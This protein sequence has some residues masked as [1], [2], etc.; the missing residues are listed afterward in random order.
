MFEIE[1]AGCTP[2][3]LMNY[4][5]ALG[6]FRLVAEQ[7][8]PTAQ[9]SLVWRSGALHTKMDRDSLLKFFLTKYCPTPIVAPWNGGSG[10]HGVVLN[11]S[12][13]IAAST[14]VRLDLYRT[15]DHND[16]TSQSLEFGKGTNTRNVQKRTADQ[17]VECSIRVSF[18]VTKGLLFPAPWHWREMTVDWNSR[19]TS[20]SVSRM[21]SRSRMVRAPPNTSS[22]CLK[23][24]LF[25]DTLV[26]LGRSAVGQFSPGSI[27]GSERNSRE[28]SR[29]RVE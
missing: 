28:V 17:V 24:S 13:A 29:L 4:L 7:A 8:D 6:V 2:E 26:S 10:F 20:C 1:L 21:S 23:S 19:T 11:H 22:T 16:S 3:P 27:G 18:S 9:L 15:S 25:A 5:K 12:I 14:S